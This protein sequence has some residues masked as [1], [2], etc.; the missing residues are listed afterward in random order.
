MP[1]LQESQTRHERLQS[2]LYLLNKAMAVCAKN[3][4]QVICRLRMTVLSGTTDVET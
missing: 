1:R 2:D 4:Y 3:T